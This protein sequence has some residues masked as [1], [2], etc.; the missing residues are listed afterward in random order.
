MPT[1][2]PATVATG[3]CDWRPTSEN[4]VEINRKPA[5]GAKMNTEDLL[6]PAAG[7]K[8]IWPKDRTTRYISQGGSPINMETQLRADSGYQ[9]VYMRKDLAQD[10]GQAGQAN[11]RDTLRTETA[12]RIEATKSYWE[13][14][15]FFSGVQLTPLQISE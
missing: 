12:N 1:G 13:G 4:L 5:T 9:R 8:R 7:L 3:R 15:P 6:R 10:L 14:F 2:F 11:R